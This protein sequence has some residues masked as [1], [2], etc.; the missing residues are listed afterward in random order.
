MRKM[1]GLTKLDK[2]V[3]GFEAYVWESGTTS[4]VIPDLNFFAVDMRTTMM[5]EKYSN[6]RVAKQPREL[7]ERPSQ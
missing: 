6:I 3:E 4:T 1:A 2:P 7:F 5:S